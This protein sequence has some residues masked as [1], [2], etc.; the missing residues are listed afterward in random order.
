MIFVAVLAF[1]DCHK[2]V[3]SS[4]FFCKGVFFHLATQF[5][6]YSLLGWRGHSAV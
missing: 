2:A 4:L 3:E 6:F 5:C 1:K